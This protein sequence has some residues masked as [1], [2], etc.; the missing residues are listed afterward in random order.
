MIMYVVDENGK[1]DL[2]TDFYFLDSIDIYK[3]FLDR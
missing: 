1:G 3:C 2:T